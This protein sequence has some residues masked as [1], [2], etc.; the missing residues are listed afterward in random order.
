LGS[1]AP[2]GSTSTASLGYIRSRLS[3]GRTEALNGKIRTITRRSF[4]FHSADALIAMI[5]LCCAGI[6]LAP[7]FVYPK[8]PT[9]PL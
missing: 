4:G 8:A 2:S 9:K 7:V 6:D 3:N 1:R 5:R